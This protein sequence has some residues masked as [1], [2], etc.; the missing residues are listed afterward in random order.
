MR[1]G[2]P[3]I[4]SLQDGEGACQSNQSPSK[5]EQGIAREIQRSQKHPVGEMFF[6]LPLAILIPFFNDQFLWR[7]PLANPH[8]E[9]ITSM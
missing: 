1:D 3:D 2:V 4:H 8:L 9:S 6:S 5:V 7:F